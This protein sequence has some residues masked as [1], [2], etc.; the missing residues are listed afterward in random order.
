M[1]TQDLKIGASYSTLCAVELQDDVV[2]QYKVTNVLSCEFWARGLND[3][4]K[5]STENGNFALRIYRKNWRTQDDIEFELDGLAYLHNKGARVAYP[6]ERKMGGYITHISAPEGIRQVILTKYAEG[7]ALKYE[8][9]TDAEKY[10]QAAAK[11]HALSSGFESKHHRYKLDIRHLITEPI[12]EIQ[13]YLSHREIDWQFIREFS[14]RLANIITGVS[15]K[16]LDYGFCHGDFH[17]FNA[18]EH[19]GKITHF[20]FDCCGFGLRAYDLATFKWSLRLGK[21]EAELWPMFLKGYQSV[22]DISE[23]DLSFVESFVA[24]RDI[25][26]MGLHMGNANDLAKGWIDE[27]YVDERMKFLREASEII[28]AEAI[29]P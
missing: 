4:Y 3:T 17:G 16:N 1:A 25:W 23:L 27:A 13:P 26:L 18:H 5:V 12:R 11:I 14:T 2:S 6:I 28:N 10:G 24:I 29:S 15:E 21:K 9:P 8:T 7:V 20:D 19:S 22:R